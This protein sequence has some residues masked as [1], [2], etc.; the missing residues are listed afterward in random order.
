MGW[1]RLY[2]D[3]CFHSL[4]TRSRAGLCLELALLV[5]CCCLMKYT[6]LGGLYKNYFIYVFPNHSSAAPG[7]LKSLHSRWPHSH[8]WQAGAGCRLGI[9]PGLLAWGPLPHAPL[10]LTR[11]DFSWHGS[12]TVVISYLIAGFP[13]RTKA[14]AISFLTTEAHSSFLLHF[15]GHRAGLDSRGGAINGRKYP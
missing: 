13:H 3:E 12:F 6:K 5:M 8:G 2:Q 7:G 4:H 15:V 14:E 10:Y 11:L 9:P 1:L